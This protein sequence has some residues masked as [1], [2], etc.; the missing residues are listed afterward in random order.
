MS[1]AV[2][3]D[4]DSA[5][6]SN[7]AA[8]IL[9]YLLHLNIHSRLCMCPVF[10]QSL[11]ITSSFLPR[12]CASCHSYRFFEVK[13]FSNFLFWWIAESP[14]IFFQQKGCGHEPCFLFCFD[15]DGL[16]RRLSRHNNKY[17]TPD[18][19]EVCSTGNWY[20]GYVEY[21]SLLLVEQGT[22]RHHIAY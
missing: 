19:V 22:K 12:S 18:E 10:I 17:L 1:L 21:L 20:L 3:W 7:L 13:V 8:Q 11:I 15:Q 14:S 4:T 16:V 5:L 6:Q 9:S 2:L